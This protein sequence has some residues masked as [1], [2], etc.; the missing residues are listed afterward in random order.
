[1]RGAPDVC[2]CFPTGRHYPGIAERLARAVTVVEGLSPIYES[3]EQWRT[4]RIAM[5]D[6]ETTGLDSS[7]D[8]VIEIG[9]ATFEDGRISGLKNWLVN[10]GVPVSDEILKLTKIDMAEL[11][12]APPFEAVVDEFR[13]MLIG[14]LPAAYNANFDAGFLRA[15]LQRLPQ[16]PT[17][18]DGGVPPAFDPTVTWID[19]LVW[20]RELQKEE[21]SKKL[22]DVCHRLGIPLDDAHRAAS[23]AEAAGKVLLALADRLPATYGELVRVQTNYAARQEVDH[24]AKFRRR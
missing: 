18:P 1:M 20:V 22:G 10:P 4:A 15:E 2:G 17:G 9:V 7:V 6:F 14:H 11:N 24:A 3:A 5:L 12:Q 21:R 23:D 19:P 8:R 16:V 13:D